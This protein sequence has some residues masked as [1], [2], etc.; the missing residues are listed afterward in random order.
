MQTRK[1]V[2]L[3]GSEHK[4]VTGVRVKGPI[5][6]DDP[7]E[8]PGGETVCAPQLFLWTTGASGGAVQVAIPHAVRRH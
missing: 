3:P 7:V 5:S 4:P 8:S 2:P 1:T 6:G